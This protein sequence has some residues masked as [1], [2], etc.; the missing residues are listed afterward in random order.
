MNL[1][2]LIHLEV[3]KSIKAP[4]S[5]VIIVLCDSLPECRAP[6]AYENISGKSHRK[7]Y[8]IEDTIAHNAAESE[9]VTP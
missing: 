9:N 3:I 1:R 6:K 4:N 8:I 5:H 2:K 7:F